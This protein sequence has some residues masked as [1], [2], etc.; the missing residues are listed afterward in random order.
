MTSTP[1]KRMRAY[2]E[3]LRRQG[4]R[5]VQLWVPDTRSPRFAAAARRQSR[6][7]RDDPAEQEIMDFIEAVA[8]TT[9]WR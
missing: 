2:R 4:L 5:A 7:I 9:G 6:L 3:R 1:K 8:D